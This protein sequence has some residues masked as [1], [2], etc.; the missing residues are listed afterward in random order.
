MVKAFQDALTT[1]KTFPKPVIAAPFGGTLAG[2]CEICLAAPMVRAAAETYMG[3]VEV[4][5]GLRS[6]PGKGRRRC[7]FEFWRASPYRP[8]D[9]CPK[10]P[11]PLFIGLYH[12]Q[13]E[14]PPI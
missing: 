6:P 14:L 5:V 12:D 3:L 7:S 2:G 10:T 8:R 9:G 11:G 4:G 13:Q 1:L